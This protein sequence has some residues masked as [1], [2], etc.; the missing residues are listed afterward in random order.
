VAVFTHHTSRPTS[1][2]ATEPGRPPDPQLHSHAFI[3]NLAF[4]QGRFLAIDSRPVY[5]FATTAEAI[6]SCELAAELQRLGYQL[7]WQETR[8]GRTWELAGVDRR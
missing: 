6:Y 2:T 4:C 1:E 8:K 7:T 5:Q 3:F